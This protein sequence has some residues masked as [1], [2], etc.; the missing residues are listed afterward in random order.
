[1]NMKF[2]KRLSVMV[3]SA[4]GVL[5]V[6]LVLLETF[7]VPVFGLFNKAASASVA[8]LLL[9]IIVL[10]AL[11]GIC[12]YSFYAAFL[13]EKAY[14]AR[15]I[16]LKGTND[17][18]V[19]IKQETM[20]EF[21]GSVI[22]KPEG[23][24]E[25]SVATE[26]RDMALDVTITMAVNMDADIAGLTSGIQSV[27]REQLE[28][29]NG[30][31]L[32]RVAVIISGI[33]VPENTDGIKMPWADK[34]EEETAEET[35]ADEQTDEEMIEKTVEEAGEAEEAGEEIEEASEETAEATVEDAIEEILSPEK[36]TEEQE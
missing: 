2:L 19:F 7:G 20:D 25:V 22:G 5:G 32:S 30:I 27:V 9:L 15:M 17:D 31:K 21:V 18:V 35:K 3:T 23:V 24:T 28:K 10:I 6:L 14:K 12:A 16:T 8:I 34:K 33:N 4:L 26:Y 11:A 13:G 1:M 36:E 29:V